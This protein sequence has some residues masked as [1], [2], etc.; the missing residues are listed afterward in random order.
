MFSL[1]FSSSFSQNCSSPPALSLGGRPQ[2]LQN[3][4][5]NVTPLK[6]VL[7]LFRDPQDARLG[8][9]RPIGRLDEGAVLLREEAVVGAE[10]VVT[11]GG[12][13]HG[14]ASGGG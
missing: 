10:V 8:G 11:E 13:V 12:D 5:L 1:S 6:L 4:A 3:A 7:E 2:T 9:L 14:F